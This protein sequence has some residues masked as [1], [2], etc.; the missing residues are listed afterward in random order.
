MKKLE[1]FKGIAE[2]AVSV[3]VGMIVGNG[4]RMTTPADIHVVKK[5]F[6]GIGSMALSGM[7][8]DKAADYT[9]KQIDATAER[10]EEAI[11]K[12]KESK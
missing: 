10:V 6:V 11:K 2:L 4:V 9:S 1:I 7:I 5:V 3:G 12:T 8:S